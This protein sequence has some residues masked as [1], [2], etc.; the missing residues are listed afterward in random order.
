MFCL[1]PGTEWLEGLAVAI[2]GQSAWQH[3]VLH[4]HNLVLF[5]V[6]WPWLSGQT[7]KST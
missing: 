1:Y 7:D 3:R 4:A 5:G 2:S 6:E